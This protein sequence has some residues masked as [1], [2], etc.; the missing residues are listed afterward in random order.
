[1]NTGNETMD[2]YKTFTCPD[3]QSVHTS[4]PKPRGGTETT[5][6]IICD[7]CGTACEVVLTEE[8][9]DK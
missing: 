6:I 4:P 2:I 8:T 7:Q 9:A 5:T 3:C 1:M